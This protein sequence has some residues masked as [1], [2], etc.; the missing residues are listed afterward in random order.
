[1]ASNIFKSVREGYATEGVGK[2]YAS[3]GE[4]YIN[5]HEIYIAE[6]LVKNKNRIDY[7]K[8]LDLS[9]GSGEVTRALQTLGYK[10]MLGCDPFTAKLYCEK[11]ACHCLDYAFTDFLLPQILT[12]PHFETPF[13]SIIC[14]FALHLAS[15]KILYSFVQAMWQLSDTL[16][17][18]TPH[19]RPVLEKL[20]NT[21]LVFDDFTLTAREK[22]IFLKCYGQL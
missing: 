2:Y 7:N 8:V 1:M 12:N 3:H 16:I 6:L 13:S 18:I 14:S 10:N 9:C 5:P 15:E 19:K 4:T 20:Q 11:T 22:K 17:I 21:Q